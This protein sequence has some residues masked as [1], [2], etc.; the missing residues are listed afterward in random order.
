[1]VA[2]AAHCMNCGIELVPGAK[3]CASCGT[4]AGA[5]PAAQAPGGSVPPAPPATASAPPE[6]PP[7]A[8]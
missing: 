2:A 4:P 3:F 7:P 5:A 1:V 8:S 6:V